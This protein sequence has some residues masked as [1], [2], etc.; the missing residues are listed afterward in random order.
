MV[1]L[2]IKQPFFLQIFPINKIFC[3]QQIFPC[4]GSHYISASNSVLLQIDIIFQHSKLSYKSGK[5][6]IENSR[7]LSD[8]TH[9]ILK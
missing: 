4:F 7:I 9:F 3:Y 5:Q 1:R 2:N 8:D 6:Q